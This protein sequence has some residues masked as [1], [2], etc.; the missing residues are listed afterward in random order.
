MRRLVEQRDQMSDAEG[1]A[2]HRKMSD[3]GGWEDKLEA[4]GELP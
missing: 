2:H 1:E 3:A 4:E